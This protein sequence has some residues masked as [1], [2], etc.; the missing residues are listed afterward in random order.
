VDEILAALR[1]LRDRVQSPV[2]RTCLEATRADIAHLATGDRT[3][4]EFDA[5][6]DEGGTAA[7]E[8]NA[9]AA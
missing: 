6:E 8:D 4:D 2:I 3:L 9:L 5:Q 1:R 7:H